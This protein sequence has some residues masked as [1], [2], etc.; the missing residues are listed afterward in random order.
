MTADVMSTIAASRIV[1][2]IVSVD[3]T[4]APAL[5]DALQDGATYPMVSSRLA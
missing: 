5:A 2:V 3:P 4:T 1:P